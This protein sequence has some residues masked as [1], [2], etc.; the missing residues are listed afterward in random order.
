MLF[1]I[2][3]PNDYNSIEIKISLI[4]FTFALDYTINAF[5]FTRKTIHNIFDIEGKYDFI[6]QLPK[7]IYSFLISVVINLLMSY[8]SLSEKAVI[9]LRDRVNKNNYGKLLSELRK[10][11]LIK[12]I[13]F[14]VLYILFLLIFWFYIS[15]FCIVYKNSQMYLIKDNLIGFCLSLI[16]PIGYYLAPGIFR[17]PAL[18]DN[19]KNKANLYSLSQMIQSI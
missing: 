9:S 1:S 6:Y 7:I 8:L 2:F 18:R 19:K 3:N 13:I 5:F 14:F 16:S 10:I 11:L 17:I 12:L 4:L 15:L